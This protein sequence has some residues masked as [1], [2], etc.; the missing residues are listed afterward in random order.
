MAAE[1]IERTE[2]TE[3]WRWA[4]LETGLIFLLFAFYAAWAVPDVNEAHYLAKA[5]HYWNADW[6]SNDFF[7][8]SADAHLV[9]YW[10]FGWVTL[11]MPLSAAAWVGRFLTWA[12]LAWSWRR[13]S[14]S[15]APQRTMSVLTAAGFTGLIYC[16]QMAGEWVIGGVEAKGFAFVCLFLA[17]ECVVK[18][19][20]RSAWLLVGAGAAFHV[21]VGGWSF[22]ALGVAW[23]LADEQRPGL[24]KMAPAV[25]AALV[26][27]L[28]GL[29]PALAL[30]WNADPA[31]VGQANQIYVFERLSH[32]LTIRRMQPLV[33]TET[34]KLPS[35]LIMRH[36]GLMIAWGY[37][38]L[39]L[40]KEI[41]LRRLQGFAAGCVM[42][43][44][45]GL[46]ID[47]TTLEH[48]EW[49]AKLLRY[50]WYRMSDVVT[51]IGVAL[52]LSV[53]IRRLA[54]WKKP[55]GEYAVIWAVAGC[56]AFLIMSHNERSGD[57]RPAADR[58][59]LP[60]GRSQAEADLI[61]DQWR[62]VCQWIAAE[63]PPDAIVITPRRQQTFTWRTGR[64]EVVNW[65][66]I[67]QD[68][69][70]IVEWK[71]RIDDLYPPDLY[72]DDGWQ[73]LT[74]LGPEH[75]QELAQQYNAKYLL[76][77][78]M[79][80]WRRP[81]LVRLYPLPG[82]PPGIYEVYLVPSETAQNNDD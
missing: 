68:A 65:K 34:F 54:D 63:T 35:P 3:N 32:H 40:R 59:T 62:A 66:N 8:N 37:L 67:P 73:G 38:A 21:L 1:A 28:L 41:P 27:S 16:C 55:V 69:A 75:L 25:I 39:A 6:A 5:K 46:I 19:R 48:P 49:G 56:A 18:N 43:A 45:A 78:R 51:P 22:V 82:D 71:R 17:L 23:L 52:A 15:I 33:L 14:Y 26:I 70:G 64:A 79:L 29:V 57:P 58:Q 9:F 7:L 24:L 13:L 36:V 20:W 44:I 74:A 80:N 61:Y 81:G 11:L 31:A 72:A 4:T 42:I 30:S 2:P 53:L 12:L 60:R 10:A 50:Y 76:V 47:V 77:D